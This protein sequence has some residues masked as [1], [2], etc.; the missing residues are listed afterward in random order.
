[1]FGPWRNIAHGLCQ[2]KASPVREAVDDNRETREFAS[3]ALFPLRYRFAP[4]LFH[5]T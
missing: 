4:R 2:F 1:M 3:I 5:T